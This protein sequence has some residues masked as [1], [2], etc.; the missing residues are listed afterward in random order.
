MVLYNLEMSLLSK[1]FGSRGQSESGD[2]VWRVYYKVDD[3]DGPG[4]WIGG[5][6]EPLGPYNSRTEAI[7]I[8]RDKAQPDGE[9]EIRDTRE[10]AKRIRKGYR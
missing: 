5:G 8:A 9:V 7:D 10:D 1:I 4:W 2:G 6:T 3:Y